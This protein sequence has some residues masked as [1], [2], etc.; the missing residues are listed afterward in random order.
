MHVVAFDDAYVLTSQGTQCPVLFPYEPAKQDVHTPVVAFRC[1]PGQ[2]TSFHTHM[3]PPGALVDPGGHGI[4][5]SD[6]PEPVEAKLA[7]HVH[8]LE[9]LDDVEFAGHK[10]QLSWPCAL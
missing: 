10:S 2:E 1:P 5:R 7:L 9:P 8:E 3:E 4:Q 6:A